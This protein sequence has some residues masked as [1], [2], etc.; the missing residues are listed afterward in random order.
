MKKTQ[1]KI[2]ILLVCVASAG[3]AVNPVTGENQLMLVGQDWELQVGRQY[4][5]ESDYDKFVLANLND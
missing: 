1:L 5:G 4:S 2:F 3:C